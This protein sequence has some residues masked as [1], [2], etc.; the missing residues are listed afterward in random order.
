MTHGWHPLMARYYGDLDDDQREDRTRLLHARGIDAMRLR[1]RLRR[2]G[3]LMD[4]IAAC[5]V[6]GTAIVGRRR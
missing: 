1:A 4:A 6:L 2:R 5:H 3:Q